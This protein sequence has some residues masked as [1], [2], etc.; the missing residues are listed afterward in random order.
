VDAETGVAGKV[1]T[2]RVVD[3]YAVDPGADLLA[4]GQCQRCCWHAGLSTGRGRVWA[5]GR[6]VARWDNVA[7]RSEV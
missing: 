1:A 5:D 7:T 6:V 3:I 2:G 4:V